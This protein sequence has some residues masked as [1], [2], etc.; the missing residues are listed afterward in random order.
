MNGKNKKEEK[1]KPKT[2]V[3]KT[4]AVKKKSSSQNIREINNIKPITKQEIHIDIHPKVVDDIENVTNKLNN[5]IQIDFS[6]MSNKIYS[7]YLEIIHNIKN[8]LKNIID[9]ENAATNMKNAKLFN[10][11]LTLFILVLT[12]A[13]FY[14]FIKNKEVVF[15]YFKELQNKITVLIPREIN[16]SKIINYLGE[17]MGIL[18]GKGIYALFIVICYICMYIFQLFGVS[19]SYGIKFGVTEIVGFLGI[20]TFNNPWFW[21]ILI[22]ILLIIVIIN[23]SYDNI[24]KGLGITSDYFN[25]IGNEIKHFFTGNI[26]K[27]PD[28]PKDS[29]TTGKPVK[30]TNIDTSSGVSSWV[31]SGVSSGV[32]SFL[33]SPS[34]SGENSPKLDLDLDISQISKR[35]NAE[36]SPINSKG[37]DPGIKKR[38]SWRE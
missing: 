31:S 29:D 11:F 27:E 13:C 12:I 17:N 5:S 6:N 4:K 7:K 36:P 1:Y 20:Y 25:K 24:Q 8:S 26:F 19:L 32:S 15:I 30:P 18:I 23:Y 14:P 38:N 35:S 16:I 28:T 9:S 2:K 34:T 21:G 3:V 33:S 37:S 22:S 10:T